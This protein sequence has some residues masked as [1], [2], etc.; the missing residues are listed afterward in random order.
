MR[1]T[2]LHETELETC[3]P[4][5]CSNKKKSIL[6]YRYL[7]GVGA[8]VFNPRGGDRVDLSEFKA[9]PVYIVSFRIARASS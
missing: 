1:L 3:S 6:E 9:R 8:H 5:I 7:P 4:V 2:I